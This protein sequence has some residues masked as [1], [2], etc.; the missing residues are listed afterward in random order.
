MSQ[1]ILDNIQTF[2]TVSG[3]THSKCAKMFTAFCQTKIKIMNDKEIYIFDNTLKYYK[4]VKREY[5]M[6]LIEE[7]II[8]HLE[9]WLTFMYT[10]YKADTE[11][12]KK[13]QEILI[14][15]I[16]HGIQHLESTPYLKNVL[17]QVITKNTITPDE[18]DNLN[19]LP[20]YLNFKNVKLNLKTLEYEER[21]ENDFVTEVLSYDSVSYT[22]LTLPTIYS[23]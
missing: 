15:N 3:L 2:V 9:T 1:T 7:T 10:S 19:Y 11:S 14:S 5:L 23:V 20:N 13:L 18:L 4:K 22:H 16:Q 6:K 8:P 17:E 12:S 21:T